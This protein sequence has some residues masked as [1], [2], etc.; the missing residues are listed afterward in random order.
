M[1]PD[2]TAVEDARLHLAYAIREI[3]SAREVLRKAGT[4]DALRYD[5]A[6]VKADLSAMRIELDVERDGETTP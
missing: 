2:R 3:E 5:L 4:H 6:G 1:T